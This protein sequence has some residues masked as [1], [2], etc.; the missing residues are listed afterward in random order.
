MGMSEKWGVLHENKSGSMTVED[1]ARALRAGASHSYQ[2]VVPMSGKSETL[3]LFPLSAVGSRARIIAWQEN[4]AAWLA[5]VVRS[6]GK[7]TGSLLSAAPPGLSEK[8]YLG[9]FPQ[10]EDGISAPLS[11]PLFN[12]GMAWSGGYWTANTSEWRNGG[13]ACSLSA[14]LEANPDPKY[15]LS[16][17]ACMGILR[18]VERRGTQLPETLR[19]A[20][21][22]RASELL[23][24][25]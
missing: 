2:V 25:G 5:T 19:Q 23:E 6:G 10:M 4:A 9:S 7:C 22:H 15:S 24:Q 16:P 3:P 12:S 8:M 1:H 18:R 13:V 11:A 20:L 21:E 17:K 14:I